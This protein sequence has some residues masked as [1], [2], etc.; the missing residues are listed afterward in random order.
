MRTFILIIITSFL[1]L[2][3]VKAQNLSTVQLDSLY[4]KFVHFKNPAQTTGRIILSAPEH[5]KCGFGIISSIKYYYNSFTPAQKKVI[6]KL[7]S[8]P[9]NDTS[10]V[11]PNGFFRIHFL[12][13]DFPN[14]IPNN[15]RTSIPADQLQKFKEIYLD[16][17]G[18][19]LDSA[20]NFEVNY[21]GYPPPPSDGMAGGDGKYDIYIENN[22]G[23]FGEYGETDPENE[24]GNTGTYTSYMVISDDYSS[25]SYYTHG[26]DAARVTV[27]H[28]FH[29]S[30]QIGNYI[31]RYQ[32]DGYFYE[33][34]ST[35]MEHFVYPTIRDYV[36]YLPAYFSYTQSTFT[37]NQGNEEYALAIWNIYLKDRFGYGIIKKQW[38]LMPKMRAIVAIN[39]S[40][41]E[42]SSSF[43]TEFSNF[44]IWTYFTGYRAIKGKYFEDAAFYPLVRPAMSLHFNSSVLTIQGNTEPLTNTFLSIQKPSASSEKA[45]D[46]L[47]IILTNFDIASGIDSNYSNI[48]FEYNLYSAKNESNLL[49]TDYYYYKFSTG[50]PTLW[51]KSAIL[52]N[53]VL[54]A[55]QSGILNT[56]YV[57]PSP[58]SYTKNY[59]L[60]FPAQYNSSGYAQLNVYDIS[61][62]LVYSS[63]KKIINDGG[64]QVLIWNAMD[65]NNAK[66]PSG[67]YIYVVK[68]GDNISKGKLVIFK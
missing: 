43:G 16:S 10:F 6:D 25:S 61:L 33:L 34:T 32:L 42:Y 3:S 15:L 48:S 22:L 37:Q 52:N 5:I 41:L 35:S 7:L 49:L 66:L 46:S 9:S 28:E 11:S 59:N 20:Y 63:S 24:I 21:L 62:R 53:L 56:D 60:H 68:S 8:R 54:V 64:K 26:I 12:K 23:T 65:N 45:P 36:N 30:I 27:A 44:G 40:L 18:I 58:F 51:L 67:V 47:Y 31:Y 38:E 2:T 14:Y 19:A 55:G 17:L 50:Q 39:Q 29:H 57:Y 4:N 13:S 1:T